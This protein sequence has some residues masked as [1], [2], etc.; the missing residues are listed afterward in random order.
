MTIP[1]DMVAVRGL[2]KYLKDNVP[3]L[4]EV[5]DEW[6]YHGDE[7]KIPCCTVITAG[8]PAYTN[9]M[10]YTWKR[11]PDPDNAQNDLVYDIIG[12]IDS[13]IQV[14]IWTEYKIQR[15]RILDLVDKALN[16]QL[17]EQDLPAGLSLILEEYHNAIARYD[18]VGYTYMDGEQESQK[19]NW[20]VKLDLVVNYP[21]IAVK[22]LPRISEITITHEIGETNSIDEETDNMDIQ[23]NYEI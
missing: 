4:L 1:F 7:M 21:K 5:Y 2:Q 17:F 16:K 6:P 15:G 19:A 12:M 14:D 9:L 23:E 22:S 11:E 18:Q 13:R 8:T 20:R 3:E 10:P